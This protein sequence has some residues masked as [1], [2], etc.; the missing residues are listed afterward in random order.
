[1]CQGYV[2]GYVAESPASEASEVLPKFLSP[3][4]RGNGIKKKESIQGDK[5]DITHVNSARGIAKESTSALR[6]PPPHPIPGAG[7]WFRSPP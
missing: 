6:T 5:Q 4:T 1:M 2:E 7:F 3:N